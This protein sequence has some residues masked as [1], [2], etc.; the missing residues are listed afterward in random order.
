MARWLT[1]VLRRVQD[2]ALQR[3]LRLTA[4]ASQ[5]IAAL[6]LDPE[7]VRD[8]LMKLKS[9][10]LDGRKISHVTGEWLYIFKR[11]AE[12]ELVY[13]KLILRGECVLVSFHQDEE[14]DERNDEP[15]Q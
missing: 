2:L 12:E 3:R 5:E 11:H 10:D 13:I 6:G 14:D 7:D 1:K 15:G 8:A 9:A 4:K